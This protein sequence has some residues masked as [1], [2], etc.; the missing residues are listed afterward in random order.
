[1]TVF[2]AESLTPRSRRKAAI[3]GRMT[4][5]ST[6][7]ELAVTMKSRV[8][9]WVSDGRLC[10]SVAAGFPLAV[11][12]EPSP[13]QVAIPFPSHRTFSFPE[14]GGPTV[15]TVHPAQG[16]SHTPACRCRYRRGPSH[17]ACDSDSVAIQT[18]GLYFSE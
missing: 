18:P 9:E 10:L 12:H 3:R 16:S 8:K 6:C 11:P 7:R 17:T 5:S 13:G 4:S 15:F 14:Y 1:M 2:S